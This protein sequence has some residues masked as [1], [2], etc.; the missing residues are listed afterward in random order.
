MRRQKEPVSS[1][2]EFNQLPVAPAKCKRA[3]HKIV[4]AVGP[5]ERVQYQGR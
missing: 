1:S 5:A 3:F 4:H 2:V